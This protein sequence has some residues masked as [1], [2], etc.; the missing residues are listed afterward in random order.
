M[1]RK[2]TKVGSASGRA[3]RRYVT[4]IQKAIVGLANALLVITDE[5]PEMDR[6]D[7]QGVIAAKK[8]CDFDGIPRRRVYLPEALSTTAQHK[9]RQ[10]HAYQADFLVQS[11]HII[12]ISMLW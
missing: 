8:I 2:D 11:I 5:T 12:M 1:V 4:G 6:P 9:R 3:H 7:C 10:A